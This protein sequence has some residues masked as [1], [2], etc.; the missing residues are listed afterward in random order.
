MA[1]STGSAR[2]IVLLGHPVA[3]SLSAVFQNAAIAAAGIAAQYEAVDV[4]PGS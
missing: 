4:A 3:H 1:A 2:R